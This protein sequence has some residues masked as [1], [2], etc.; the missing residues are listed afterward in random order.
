MIN[1]KALREKILD[2][3]MR[4]KLVEQVPTDESASELL[5]KIQTEK[6]QLAKEK[7]IKK[8]KTLPEISEEEVP[9]EIPESWE[10]VRIQTIANYVQR[11]KSP[12]YSDIKKYPVIS[13]K[14]IQWSGMDM[15]PARFIVPSSIE[16]YD[17]IRM[18]K[19][20]DI[21]WNSTGTG[22]VGRVGIIGTRDIDQ[23]EK[24]VV[25]SH[26]TIVR[27][28]RYIYSKYLFLYLSSA[29]VQKD[30]D[31][32]VSGTTKQK[33]LSL[34][35]VLNL[36]ISLPPF[37]EQKRIVSKIEELFALIDIIETNL[38]DYNQLAE[39]LDKKVLDLA[40][41]GKLVEQDPSDEPA[42]KL[43]KKVQA[44]K[45]RLVKE[46]KIKKEKP[47]PE[48]REEEV[49]FD[50]PESWEWAHLQNVVINKDSERVPLPLSIRNKHEKL[51]DYYGASG[52][53]DRVDT[54]L[55][56]KPLLL[57]AEDGANLKSRATAVA[58][59]AY[60]KYWVNN[61]AHVVDSL[62]IDT[63]LFLK[64]YLNYIS[65]LPYITGSAQPKMN[66]QNMGK[67]LIPIP[68]IKEQKRI[69][70]KVEEIKATIQLSS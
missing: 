11:G 26:V 30:M 36:N 56:E 33:E 58:F 31:S 48:I 37:K 7:K 14:C 67:I 63:L 23:Y 62:Y 28:S 52:V 24:V 22:T 70:K 35:A 69:V 16:K 64:N 66:Q 6:E 13:Q 4:G 32:L 54:Y 20:D 1:T 12:Q 41:R 45:E 3:A 40:M 60:G 15:S 57:I 2:L 51:Y 50:I 34:S 17:E 65:L 43:L 55:F 47:L 38:T 46:K 49:P 53:I 9:F 68:P 10:W 21:L 61:H 59:M 44:E 29:I 5:K 25:D 8:E 39:H 19:V 18:V 27:T 42:S